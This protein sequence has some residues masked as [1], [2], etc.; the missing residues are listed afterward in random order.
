MK[1]NS[2]VQVSALVPW[3]SGVAVEPTVL[4]RRLVSCPWQHPVAESFSFF[5]SSSHQ[6]STKMLLPP[7]L[8]RKWQ[9]SNGKD[10]VIHCPSIFKSVCNHIHSLA[11]LN[12]TDG[13]PLCCLR[14]TSFTSPFNQTSFHSPF[15]FLLAFG[16]IVW[17]FHSAS[18]S[19][20]N[21]ASTPAMP[22][23]T[24]CSAP[25][26]DSSTSSSRITVSCSSWCS[27]RLLTAFK[28]F[29]F[30]THL[31]LLQDTTSRIHALV[32]SMETSGGRDLSKV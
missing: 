30:C 18:A 23:G 27:L 32:L 13:C 24:L 15:F 4:F 19:S 20:M 29:C 8:S 14:T 16:H 26:K 31:A 25:L 17:L 3:W 11:C 22:G 2:P 21:L 28:T 12:P 10:F 6:H 7:T 5:L 9:R 1:L